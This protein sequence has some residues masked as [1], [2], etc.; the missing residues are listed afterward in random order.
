VKEWRR[1]GNESER[2]THAEPVSGK[3]CER[4]AA[5]FFPKVLEIMKRASE[6]VNTVRSREDTAEKANEKVSAAY[7]REDTVERENERGV[8]IKRARLV[9]KRCEPSLFSCYFFTNGQ[10]EA[11]SG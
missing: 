7:S 3:K 1:A 10:V 11:E 9:L 2:G 8:V 4:S 5:A 6:R